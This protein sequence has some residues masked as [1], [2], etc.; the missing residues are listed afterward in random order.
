MGATRV[1]ISRKRPQR[2]PD[3]SDAHLELAREAYEQH[4]RSVDHQDLR[5]G[6]FL[7]AVAFFVTSGTTGLLNSDVRSAYFIMPGNQRIHLPLLFLASFLMMTALTAAYLVLSIGPPEPWDSGSEGGVSH[8]PYYGSYYPTEKE[9]EARFQANA[10]ELSA[11]RYASH[12]TN[13]LKAAKRA[14][15][16]YRRIVEARAAFFIALPLFSLFIT[17]MTTAWNSSA[18]TGTH[19]DWRPALSGAIVLSLLNFT[20]GEDRSRIEDLA[21]DPASPDRRVFSKLAAYLSVNSG[22][23]FLCSS[24]DGYDVLELCAGGLG[25]L[26]M[27]FAAVVLYQRASTGGRRVLDRLRPEVVIALAV[28]GAA[29]LGL[30]VLR[31]WCIAFAFIPTGLFEGVRLID[32]Y[33]SVEKSKVPNPQGET[34]GK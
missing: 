32:Y 22:C 34:S 12:K 6:R 19:W 13:T 7:T 15:Y 10:A 21:R 9:W 26:S 8:L 5:T 17:T 25:I 16:K 28:P 11:R 27:V 14:A 30:P 1:R 20:A 23:V 29:A 18:S 31:P 3:P 4:V 33:R 24:S 2:A